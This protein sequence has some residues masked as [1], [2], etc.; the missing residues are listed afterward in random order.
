MMMRVC[1]RGCGSGWGGG[2]EGRVEWLALVP[3]VANDENSVA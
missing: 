3:E 1:V 2:R